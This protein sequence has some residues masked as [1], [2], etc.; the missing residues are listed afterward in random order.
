M[1]WRNEGIGQNNSTSFE[2]NTGGAPSHY[3]K[4]GKNN[5]NFGLIYYSSL[6]VS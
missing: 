1:N 5:K 2:N 4:L 6:K 3:K